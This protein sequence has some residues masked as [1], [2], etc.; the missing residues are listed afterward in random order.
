VTAPLRGE[1]RL[2]RPSPLRYAVTKKGRGSQ[3]ADLTTGVGSENKKQLTIKKSQRVTPLLAQRINLAGNN[4]F[5]R[6]ASIRI[7]NSV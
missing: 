1:R 7:A 6:T 2:R 3:G 4:D 5:W